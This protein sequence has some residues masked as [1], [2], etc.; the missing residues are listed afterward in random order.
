MEFAEIERSF[1]SLETDR[2]QSLW[3][4]PVKQ[5]QTVTTCSNSQTYIDEIKF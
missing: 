4:Q 2:L 3:R 5:E 1:K